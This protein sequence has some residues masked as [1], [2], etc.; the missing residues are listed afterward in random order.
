MTMWLTLLALV[1]DGGTTSAMIA[2]TRG[3]TQ[4]VQPCRTDAEADEIL[5]CAARR[6]DRF[7]VPLT[8]PPVEGD[9][10]AVDALGERERLLA[11]PQPACG[12]AAFLQRCGFVGVTASTR[13]GGSIGRP[14]PLA[15]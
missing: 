7:R 15:Q 14:R 5:V 13:K 1:Q 10:K 2:R 3:L 12:T 11:V 4:V 6:A 9:P 8:T